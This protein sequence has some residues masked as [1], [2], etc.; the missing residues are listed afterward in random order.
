[1]NKTKEKVKGEST[2][3]DLKIV[4]PELSGWTKYSFHFITCNNGIIKLQLP[5]SEE[6]TIG[7]CACWI[8]DQIITALSKPE[9][10]GD[11]EHSSGGAMETKTIPGYCGLINSRVID[12]GR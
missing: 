1:M 8:P 5:G 3:K 2:D 10:S 12:L 9:Q 7:K 4:C 11:I 6:R